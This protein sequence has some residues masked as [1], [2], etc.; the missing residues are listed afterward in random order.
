MIETGQAVEIVIKNIT[1]LD[2]SCG[3]N[4][5]ISLFLEQYY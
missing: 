3:I 2:V 1:K 4:R 5:E